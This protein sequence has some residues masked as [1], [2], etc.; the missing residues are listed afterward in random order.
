MA[1]GSQAINRR[2]AIG[3]QAINRRMDKSDPYENIPSFS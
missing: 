2:M 1:M 3:S